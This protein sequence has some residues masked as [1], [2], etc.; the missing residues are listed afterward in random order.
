MIFHLDYFLPSRQQTAPIILNYISDWNGA[1]YFNRIKALDT[2]AER[3]R[4][5]AISDLGR[6][7]SAQFLS[8]S[9]VTANIMCVQ[10]P[11]VAGVM[12]WPGLSPL[13]SA[14][15]SSLLRPGRGRYFANV[16]G[17]CSIISQAQ[18]PARSKVS[19]AGAPPWR[20][21]SRLWLLTSEAGVIS[22]TLRDTK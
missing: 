10:T 6:V 13:H 14:S 22:E 1:F 15:L 21:H 9:L 8:V 12:P 17:T 11:G 7:Q 19:V 2:R 5:M 16:M 18:D 4:T 20:A 3:D